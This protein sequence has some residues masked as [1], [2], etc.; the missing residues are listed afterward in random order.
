M[1]GHSGCS[2]PPKAW[3]LT[4]ARAVY[5]LAPRLGQEHVES[6]LRTGL[7]MAVALGHVAEL[8]LAADARDRHVG[9]A[10]E[11]ARQVA[12]IDGATVFVVCRS[13][14]PSA[15]ALLRGPHKAQPHGPQRYPTGPHTASSRTHRP[16]LSSLHCARA[17]DCVYYR[18]GGGS[19]MGAGATVLLSPPVRHPSINV[20]GDL[21]NSIALV[22][23]CSRTER[24]LR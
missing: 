6:F 11:I 14:A 20:G 12:F 22:R 15:G 21:E 8:D 1:G 10:D 23:P 24:I 19:S 16:K 9:L 5:G 13:R 4:L 17:S 7:E 18:F 2:T 3:H